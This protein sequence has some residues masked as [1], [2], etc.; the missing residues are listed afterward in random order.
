M[1]ADLTTRGIVRLEAKE[2]PDRDDE[3]ELRKTREKLLEQ[4]EAIAELEVFYN[5]VKNQWSD[6]GLRNIGHVR[7]AKAIS[8]DVEGGTLYTEDWGAFEVDEA[9]VKPKFEGTVVD[10]GAF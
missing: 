1:L 6:I 9:K 7:Y 4:Q 10:L 3:R 5:E 2:N 8:I